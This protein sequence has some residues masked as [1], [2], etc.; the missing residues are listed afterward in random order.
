MQKK[1][2]TNQRSQGAPSSRKRD[3]PNSRASRPPQA[4]S[5]PQPP[6]PQTPEEWRAHW[7][8]QGQP[9]RT[10]PEIDAQR[11]AELATR[12]AIIPNVEKGTYPFSEVKLSRADIEWLLT[13]HE[14][15]RGQVDWVDESQQR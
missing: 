4:P 8:A 7:E 14:N 2:P 9:W 5:M 10:E 12:R 3:P 13:T 1:E 6:A 15:G 11:Q